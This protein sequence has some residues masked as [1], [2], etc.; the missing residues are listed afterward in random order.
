MEL[1]RK[2]VTRELGKS[3]GEKIW[4]WISSSLFLIGK[5][6]N[7]YTFKKYRGGSVEG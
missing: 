4:K 2:K 1:L 5:Y 6:S 3:F 7:I